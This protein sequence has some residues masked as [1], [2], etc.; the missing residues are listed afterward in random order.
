MTDPLTA[1]VTLTIDLDV[2][3]RVVENP[4]EG[5]LY[6]VDIL[7][8]KFRGTDI[9]NL[10]YVAHVLDMQKQVHKQIN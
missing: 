10:M 6:P 9:Y 1:F 4:G 8:A 5:R 3:Y 7:K 2:E